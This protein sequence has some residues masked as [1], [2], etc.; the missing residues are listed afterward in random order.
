MYWDTE[1]IGLEQENEK[2]FLGNQEFIEE[3]RHHKSVTLYIFM[4]GNTK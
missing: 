4:A 3:L 1:N 2:D